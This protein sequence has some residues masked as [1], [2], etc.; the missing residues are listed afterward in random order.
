MLNYEPSTAT[1]GGAFVVG[2]WLTDQLLVL[3]R[4][5]IDARVDQNV[6]EGE[7]EYWLRRDLLLQG[8]AGDRG[9]LGLDLLWNRRW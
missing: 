2:T 4:S 5:R 8:T 3:Y 6:N 7:A 9:V 1:S